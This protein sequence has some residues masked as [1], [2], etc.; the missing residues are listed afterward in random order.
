M[1][2]DTTKLLYSECSNIEGINSLND[3]TGFEHVEDHKLQAHIHELTKA[4]EQ[5]KQQINKHIKVNK[6]LQEQANLLQRVVDFINYPIFYKDVQGLYQL[7]NRAFL[8]FTRLNKKEVIGK[9]GY[10]IFP[11][12]F[13]KKNQQKDLTLYTE[14]GVQTYETFFPCFDN[15]VYNVI[16]TK[17]TY[18]N[19]DATVG[20]LVGVVIDITDYKRLVNALRL[21]EERFSKIFKASPN[22]MSISTLDEGRYIDVN[23]SFVETSGYS[24]EEII[25]KTAVEIGFWVDYRLRAENIQKACAG[26]NVEI[27]CCTKTGEQRIGLFSMEIITINGDQYLLGQIHDITE[28]KQLEEEMSHLDRLNLIGEMAAGICHEI[29]NP[30]TT[31]RG[32]LQLLGEKQELVDCKAYYNLMI[33]ELDQANSIISEYLTL[34]RKKSLDLKLQNLNLIIKAIAPLIRADA[35]RVDKYIN[36]ELS[37]IPDLLL[38][39]K[40]I[41]QLIFN[42]IRNGIEAMSAGRNLSIRTYMDG[43]DVVL[44][45]EDEGAGIE[46]NL[47]KKISMP[48]FT[49]KDN[50]TGLGLA[51]CYS[52]A[53]RHKATIDVE[54]SS[55]GTTFFVRFKV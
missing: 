7:V 33:D 48:F 38:N 24:R 47:L 46:P 15:S 2:N 53:A 31:V 43:Q 54:S 42:L 3:I 55:S 52:I 49:T 22:P 20:G 23:D 10:D 12:D 40:Q 37:D 16:I 9:S 32:F 50:G 45:V 8:S 35:M 19:A 1:K 27:Y 36:L 21:S 13:A 41:R 5:L 11:K 39:D 51:V 30:L 44:S 26:N 18:T 4:N 17:A 29:K 28:R 25:G 34:A 6:V 14:P